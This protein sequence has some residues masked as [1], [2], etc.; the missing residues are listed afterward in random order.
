MEGIEPVRILISGSRARYGLSTSLSRAFSKLGCNVVHFADDEAYNESPLAN[1]RPLNR[2]LWKR[3]AR[4]VHGRF[5]AEVAALKPELLL[6]FKGFYFK[7]TTLLESRETSKAPLFI[8]NP[9]NPF[10]TWNFGSSNGWIRESIPVYD[11]YF[12]YAK[13]LLEPLRRAGARRVEHLSFASDPELHNPLGL[14]DDDVKMY[15]SDIAFVGN[16]DDERERWLSYLEG[17][18]LAIW[19]ANYWK[20]RCRNKFLR[21]SWRGREALAE[22]MVKVCLA[23]KI[24]LNILRLQNKG[25]H[26]MRTFEVPSCGGFMLHEASEEVGN[27]FD[28]G[29]E[30]DCFS[31][32]DELREKIAFYMQKPE[33]RTHMREA[34]WKKVQDHTYQHRARRILD[35]FKELTKSQ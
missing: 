21:R 29:G 12:T 23:S 18:D 2:L 13:P 16:W 19:G 25:S 9:D 22:E 31:S 1:N 3:L 33:R 10:N 7:P 28:V 14:S 8:F 4:R 11:A 27:Y 20:N 26:N 15:G 5:L 30:I 6:I 24:N 35:V 17:Y 32:P 34:A